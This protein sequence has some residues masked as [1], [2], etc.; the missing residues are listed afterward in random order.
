MMGIRI[1]GNISARNA[2]KSGL[3]RTYQMILHSVSMLPGGSMLRLKCEC[4]RMVAIGQKCKKCGRKMPV[5]QAKTK[6]DNLFIRSV[7][8]E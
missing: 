4:G 5:P 8:R 7:L 6:D 3:L 1:G 2:G